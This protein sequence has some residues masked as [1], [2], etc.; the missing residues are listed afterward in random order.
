MCGARSVC[1]PE[2]HILMCCILSICV[3]SSRLFPCSVL[4]SLLWNVAASCSPKFAVLSRC[5]ASAFLVSSWLMNFVGKRMNLLSKLRIYKRQKLIVSVVARLLDAQLSWSSRHNYN[6]NNKITMLM[7][8]RRS[9][10]INIIIHIRGD[11]NLSRA[12][13]MNSYIVGRHVVI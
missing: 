13:V 3:T 1:K 7:A 5:T 11:W 9:N 10:I 2:R 6:M 12:S 8:Y 4:L